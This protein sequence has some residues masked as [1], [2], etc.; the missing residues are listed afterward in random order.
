MIN[1]KFFIA[2]SV[3][4]K[5]K[6]KNRYFLGIVQCAK[7]RVFYSLKLIEKRELLYNVSYKR[8]TLSKYSVLTFPT[9]QILRNWHEALRRYFNGKNA[10]LAWVHQELSKNFPEVNP[11]NI[12]YFNIITGEAKQ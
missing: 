1:D 10:L 8:D 5:G 2:I 11:N 7:D 6:A 3:R 4:V 12:D 9:K